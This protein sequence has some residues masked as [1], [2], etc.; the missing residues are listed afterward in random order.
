MRRVTA[1]VVQSVTVSPSVSSL[2]LP[3]ST[4]S[5]ISSVSATCAHPAGVNMSA[6]AAL[7]RRHATRWRCGWQ[8]CGGLASVHVW[9]LWSPVCRVLVCRV[10]VRVDPGVFRSWSLC[11]VQILVSREL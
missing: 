2:P 6:S 8:S 10:L 3:A 1:A 9:T 4:A 5:V 7:V 11:G